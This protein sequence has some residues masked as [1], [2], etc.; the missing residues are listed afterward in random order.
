MGRPEPSWDVVVIGAGGSQAQAMLAAAARGTDVSR[1]LAI[2]RA[3]RAETRSTTQRLGI[4][5]SELDVLASAAEL[6]ELLAATRTVANLAG[7]YYRTG[8]AVLDAAIQAGTD[9]VDICDDADVTLPMLERGP[10]AEAAGVRALIGMGSSPGT[11]NVLI[12]AALDHLGSAED[13][14]ISWTVDI[15]DMTDAAA[16]HFWHCFNLV[17][18]DGTVHPAPS[19]AHLDRKAV[20]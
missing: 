8:T 15:N 2:D 12:R 5:T 4:A 11:S 3:W 9:Y 20:T 7:P 6:Y 13:V 10:A 17:D 18:G 19:W 1:W 16:R 14:D